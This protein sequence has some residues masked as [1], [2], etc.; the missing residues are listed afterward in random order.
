ML[1]ATASPL[2]NGKI[3]YRALSIDGRSPIRRHLTNDDTHASTSLANHSIS[4]CCLEEKSTGRSLFSSSNHQ[5][6]TL[7]LSQPKSNNLSTGCSSPHCCTSMESSDVEQRPQIFTWAHIPMSL[8]TI[9][10]LFTSIETA[11]TY[12]SAITGDL[13]GS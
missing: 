1:V 10:F 8:S 5:C 3:L 7:H 4:E 6:N 2:F 9:P 11:F 12:L 13:I